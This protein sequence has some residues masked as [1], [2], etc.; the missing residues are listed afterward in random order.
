MHPDLLKIRVDDNLGTS[1][2]MPD[3]AWRAVLARARVHR[4]PLAVHV[5]Y[6]ADARALVDAGAAFVAHSVRDVPVDRAFADALEAH[7]VC[8]SPTLTRELSTFVYGATPAFARDPF[9]QEGVTPDVVTALEDP[10]RQAAVRDSTAYRLGLRYKAALAVA[11]ENLKTLSDRGVT[12]AMG[13]DSGPPGRFQ[14]FFEHLEL[15][16]MVEAGLTPMQA[17]VAATGAAARCH[18]QGDHFGTIEP[19]RSA[20]LVVLAGNPLDDIRN[21]R[22]IEAVWIAGRRI[23]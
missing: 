6:L 11:S 21:T 8:Y 12:I 22:T 1:P 20:D 5:F 2:K 4:L 15:E 7:G 23:R 14:G 19:G 13:T 16:M 9:F 17:L 3:T 18:G 10:A